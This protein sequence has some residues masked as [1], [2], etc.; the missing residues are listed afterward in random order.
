MEYF[1]AIKRNEIL[2]YAMT[3]MNPESITISERSQT[4]KATYCMM[5]LYEMS[6][7]GKSIETEG[8]SVV[9]R[10]WGQGTMESDY[11]MGVG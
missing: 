1:S 9:A 3:W 8:K 5:H 6:R 10:G 11:I 4:Q 2:I 7:I